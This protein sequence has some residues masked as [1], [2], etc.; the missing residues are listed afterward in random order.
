M[1]CRSPGKKPERFSRL[2]RGPGEDDTFDPLASKRLDGLG[3]RKVGL[4]G[5]GRSDAH[6]DVV[7]GDGLEIIALPLSLGDN[8]ASQSRQNNFAVT[9]LTRRLDLGTFCGK[10]G[11]R[12]RA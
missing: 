3:H 8:G 6:H 11:T 4:A 1:A 12:H 7:I 9:R 10:A 2:H 5:S